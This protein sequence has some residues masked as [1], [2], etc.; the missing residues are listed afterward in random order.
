[1]SELSIRQLLCPE[2][3]HLRPAERCVYAISPPE[4][5]QLYKLEA[6]RIF[7]PAMLLILVFAVFLALMLALDM[8][9]FVT[10]MAVGYILLMATETLLR[11]GPFRRNR[12]KAFAQLGG[13][14]DHFEFYSDCLYYALRENGETVRAR[15]VKYS[16]ITRVQRRDAFLILTTNREIFYIPLRCLGSDSPVFELLLGK[17]QVTR[18][19]KRSRLTTIISAILIWVCVLLIWADLFDWLDPGKSPL[20][21][22]LCLLIPLVSFVYGLAMAIKGRG[23]IFNIIAGVLTAIIMLMSAWMSIMAGDADDYYD[24]GYEPGD[25]YVLQAEELLGIDFMEY[26]SSET[27]AYGEG[28]DE[29]RCT[30]VYYDEHSWGSF[31]R[32]MT[33]SRWRREIPS[34]LQCIASPYGSP[35]F[36]YI[37]IYNTDT[38]QYNSL[39]EQSGTY[40][41]VTLLYDS[42][43]GYIEITDYYIDFIA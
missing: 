16:E 31:S 38:G 10:G 36:D 7:R 21:L 3:A 18:R 22:G 25:E 19:S 2:S 43:W 6:R 15:Q 39:P 29:V 23:F 40:H 14:T 12:G 42:E 33:D 28:S 4:L 5:K 34:A 9:P 41:F 11:I 17:G 32:V 37:L 8:L 1:M 24:Y 13:Q 20:T 26:E 27:I 30:Y 35:Y